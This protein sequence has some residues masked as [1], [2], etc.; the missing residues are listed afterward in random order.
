LGADEAIGP[1]AA[2]RAYLTAPG[3][4]GGAPR[5]VRTGAPADLVLL[6]TPLREALAELASG[7]V[8]EVWTG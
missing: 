8:R 1:A 4:P 5:R 6:H 3:A 7:N 2:L